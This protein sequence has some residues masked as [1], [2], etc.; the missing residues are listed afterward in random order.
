L[1]RAGIFLSSL[2]PVWELEDLVLD[3]V[4]PLRRYQAQV[5]VCVCVCVC[6]SVFWVFLFGFCCC[7]FFSSLRL[8]DFANSSDLEAVNDA[9]T[10]ARFG[11]SKNEMLLQLNFIAIRLR[12]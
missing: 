11:F 10:L 4:L 1:H 5:C 7:I 3:P 12:Y 2:T 6:V 9:R 8:Q